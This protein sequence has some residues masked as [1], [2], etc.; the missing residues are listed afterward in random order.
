MDIEQ[1]RKQTGQAPYP[2]QKKKYKNWIKRQAQR[3]GSQVDANPY[4]NL[5]QIRNEVRKEYTPYYNKQTA[6]E[7]KYQYNEPLT[8]IKTNQ[9]RLQQEIAAGREQRDITEGQQNQGFNQ[10]LG[11]RGVTGSSPAAMALRARLDR[12]QTL[13]KS[14]Q[15]RG[16]TQAGQDL[17]TQRLRTL[18]RRSTFQQQ[19]AEALR[20]MIA[21]ETQNRAF[22]NYYYNQ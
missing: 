15:E 14:N 9:A 4:G 8:D 16:F 6:T 21:Q 11:A 10:D 12:I 19:R 17:N 13:N 5:T 2:N 1:Y 3:Y 20:Q 7:Q 18:D 22:Q